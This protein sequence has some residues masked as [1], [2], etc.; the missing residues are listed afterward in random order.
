MIHRPDPL[1]HR[2]FTGRVGGFWGRGTRI[3]GQTFPSSPPEFTRLSSLFCLGF[4][5]ISTSQTSTVSAQQLKIALIPRLA[6]NG[7]EQ[8]VSARVFPPSSSLRHFAPSCSSLHAKTLYPHNNMS[9]QAINGDALVAEGGSR[10]P[11]STRRLL[12]K[13]TY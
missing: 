10:H 11:N 1:V 6:C 4:H 12:R 13:L 5:V 9:K 3:A 7:D 2:A 8:Q